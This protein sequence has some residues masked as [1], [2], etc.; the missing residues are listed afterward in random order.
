MKYFAALFAAVSAQVGQTTT[1][2]WELGSV[3]WHANDSSNVRSFGDHTRDHSDTTSP[4][5]PK[6][7]MAKKAPV[8]DGAGAEEASPPPK[9]E[10]PVEDA[11]APEAAA[12]QLSADCV[13][14]P[15]P[16]YWQPYESCNEAA[17]PCG[18]DAYIRH[19]P[20]VYKFGGDIFVNSMITT[21]ALEL[22]ACDECGA[23]CVPTGS[24]TLNKTGLRVAAKEVLATHMGLTGEAQ[25]AYLD[26]Y[27]DKAF[28][29]FDVN[30]VGMI[31]VNKTPQFFRFLMSDQHME[32]GQAAWIGNRADYI[33]TRDAARSTT[34]YVDI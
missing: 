23:A 24:F 1:P 18:D 13:P 33:A 17:G 26:E 2:V 7:A 16:F 14:A 30:K 3:N 19:V 27:F 5:F 11:A 29:H 6:Q 8:D 21:Y 28:N 32:M 25:K 10:A 34:S 20:A 31:E 22:K 4:F 15:G 12:I 9:E